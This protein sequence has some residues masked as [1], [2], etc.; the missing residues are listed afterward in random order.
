MRWLSTDIR[1]CAILQMNVSN[2]D[3]SIPVPGAGAFEATHWSL[4]RQATRGGSPESFRARETLGGA[5]WLPLYS[6]ARR[7]TPDIDE[8]QDLTQAFFER[9]LERDYL[10]QADP[11]RGRFRAFLL[12]A[13]KHFLSNEWL[14]GRALKRGGGRRVIPFDFDQAESHLAVG[15]RSELT[16]EQIYDQEWAV[17]LLEQVMQ[18]LEAEQT[19]LGKLRQFSR[20]KAC[21]AHDPSETRYAEIA[22]ELQITPATARMAAVRL[23]RRYRELLRDRIARTV[24]S[25]QEID[26]EIRW[27]FETFSR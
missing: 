12:T 22:G 17:T 2:S 13:F 16:A 9:L 7:R 15:R 8:A 4:I 18:D 5:Y 21:L 6:Y 19:A 20:L 10:S 11:A 14:R 25:P 26:E 23:R 1:L 24:E 3:P 27:L